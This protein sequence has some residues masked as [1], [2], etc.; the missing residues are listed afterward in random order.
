M[1]EIPDV[2]RKPAVIVSSL[3][4]TMHLSPIVARITSVDRERSLATAVTLDPGEVDGL[5]EASFVLGHDL[6]TLP[7][8]RLIAHLGWVT[9]N[10]MLEVDKAVLTALGV[11]SQ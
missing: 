9:P 4:V 2:G 11:G 7:A 6:Y 1:A 8:G 10:R 3:P 5:T